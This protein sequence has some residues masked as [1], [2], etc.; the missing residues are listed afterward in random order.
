MTDAPNYLLEAVTN[1][2]ASAAGLDPSKV[3]AALAYADP[4]TFTDDSGK[5]DDEKIARYAALFKQAGPPHDPV[6]QSFERLRGDM[7]TMNS[8]SV[9]SVQSY[10]HDR[11]TGRGDI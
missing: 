7:N 2:V 10:A 3:S 9:A 5:I 11:M 1:K 4:T 8:G 6:L